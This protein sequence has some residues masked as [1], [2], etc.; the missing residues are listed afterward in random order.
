MTWTLVFALA[1]AAY[2]FKVIGLVVIGERQ[3]PPV[4]ERCLVLIPAALFAAIIVKDT[5]SVGQDL[6]IDARVV[7]IAAA[8]IATW[9]RAP[10]VLVIV[11]A[12]AV[13]ALVRAI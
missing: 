1:A 9:R 2:S 11:L 5:F 7:G 13:T 4:I 3:M 6:V 12:C 8:V 10:M